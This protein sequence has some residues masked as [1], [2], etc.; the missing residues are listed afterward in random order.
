MPRAY[1]HAALKK[2]SGCLVDFPLASRKI[3]GL[4]HNIGRTSRPLCHRLRVPVPQAVAATLW[5]YTSRGLLLF[6]WRYAIGIFGGL[7]YSGSNMSSR[8]L[9]CNC[10]LRESMANTTYASRVVTSSQVF[11]NT[12][13]P[14]PLLKPSSVPCTALISVSPGVSQS[15]FTSSTGTSLNL[16]FR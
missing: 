9:A 1:H 11:P 15:H 10:Q 3:N 5:D 13:I 14:L 7:E 8:E 16:P 4:V 6:A 12:K 2:I